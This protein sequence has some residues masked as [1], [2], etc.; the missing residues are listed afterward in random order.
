MF[1]DQFATIFPFF[2]KWSQNSIH[3][4]NIQKDIS[5]FKGLPNVHF[6]SLQI[7]R[8]QNLNKKCTPIIT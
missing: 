8:K 4:S 5:Y 3:L 6:L 2:Q 7:Q 1:C